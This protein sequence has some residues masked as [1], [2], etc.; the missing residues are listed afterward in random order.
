[1]ELVFD[2]ERF[3][4]R[5]VWSTRPGTLLHLLRLKWWV[6][7]VKRAPDFWWKGT[8]HRE[9]LLRF[10]ES[11]YEDRSISYVIDQVGPLSSGGSYVLKYPFSCVYDGIRTSEKDLYLF[12][13]PRGQA[14]P[15]K[16]PG[17]I[18][19]ANYNTGGLCPWQL[20]PFQ[21]TC[22]NLY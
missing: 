16:R 21:T 5:A 9:T 3:E 14:Q 7:T 15:K 22:H 13:H 2:R 8:E 17:S 12:H 18:N 10:E 6:W 20:S 11:R 4:T 19:D 1:M